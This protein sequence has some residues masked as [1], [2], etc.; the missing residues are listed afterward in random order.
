MKQSTS[1]IHT[2]RPD[3]KLASAVNPSIQRASSLLFERAVD[4]YGKSCPTYGRVGTQVHRHLEELFCALESA[5]H[6]SLTPSGLAA[7]TLAIL[8]QVKAGDKILVVDCC[9]KPV[10]H[11][12]DTVLVQYGVQ[13]QYIAANSGD[14]IEKL[15]CERTRLIVLESPGSLTLDI[16]D[17]PAIAAHAKPRNIPIIVDNT[18]SAGLGYNPL[19]LGADI[20]VHSATKYI[21]G[22]G[23]LLMGAVVSRDAFHGNLVANM[24]SALGISCA[25]D[26][27]YQV[28]RGFRTLSTRFE[29]QSKTAYELAKW[30]QTH[31]V[32]ERVLHPALPSHPQYDLWARDFKGAG[33]VFSCTLKPC[34]PDVLLQILDALKLFGK[35]FSFGGYESL[36]MQCAPQLKRTLAHDYENTKEGPHLIRLACGLEDIEDL[37]ADLQNALDLW[38]G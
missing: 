3:I 11:F 14:E 7:N 1:F 10:R 2:A 35:G 23:D 12:C 28:L 25:P 5:T 33:C 9:Y 15:L 20:V 29:V 6:C 31:P 38:Q 37:R 30:M 32:I 17:L 36:A 24:S 22:H 27:V 13:T 26:D 16:Q 21:A 4:L 19:A 34:A 8:S 18:W